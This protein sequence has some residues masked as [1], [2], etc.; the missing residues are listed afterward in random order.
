MSLKTNTK[1][2]TIVELLIVIVVIGIL[3]AITIVAFNGIQNRGK[4]AASQ[5]LANS[6]VKKAEA[7]NS[8]QGSYPS[9]CQLSTNSLSPTSTGTWPAVT[10]TAAGGT[11]PAEAKLDQTSSVTSATMTSTL[12]DSGKV[13]S[14]PVQ[15]SGTTANVVW[16][17]FDGTVGNQTIS[18]GS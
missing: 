18:L 7:W 9:Y 14:Y 11:G 15:N 13:A 16:Y 5:S 3:A 2:F 1:G 8:I 4:S 6:I 17:K 12:S 10:C